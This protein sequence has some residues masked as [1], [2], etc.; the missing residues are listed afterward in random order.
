MA[1]STARPCIRRLFD[2]TRAQRDPG[3][4]D[5]I[6][7]VGT[8]ASGATWTATCNFSSGNQ[9]STLSAHAPGLRLTIPT[10]HELVVSCDNAKDHIYPLGEN[11]PWTWR[12]GYG[13]QW[14][15]FR[16]L[17][18]LPPGEQPRGFSREIATME[19]CARVLA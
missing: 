12:D 10:S 6:A 4:I 9:N 13:F 3:V 8:F 7:G 18:D 14:R 17:L 2:T 1:A 11:L 5:L 19:F 16:R 15:E